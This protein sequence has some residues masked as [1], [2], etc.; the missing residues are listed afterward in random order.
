MTEAD[1]VL[2]ELNKVINI[3]NG[4]PETKETTKENSIQRAKE[5]LNIKRGN[6]DGRK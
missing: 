5:I 1:K 3:L 2:N 6:N 4:Y